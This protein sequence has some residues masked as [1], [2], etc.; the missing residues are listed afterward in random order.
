MGNHLR[1]CI[2]TCRYND[3]NY[4][5]HCFEQRSYIVSPS[6]AVGG[7][8]GGQVSGLFALIEDK[9]G[10][11]FR[12]DPTAIVFTDNEFRNYFFPESKK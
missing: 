9:K 10:N 3:K 2:R 5:F 12:V 7:H 11:I 6:I 4:L 1:A 8:S